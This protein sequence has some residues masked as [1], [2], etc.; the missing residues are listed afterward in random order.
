MMFSTIQEW[1]HSEMRIQRV[2]AHFIGL[3]Q[4]ATCAQLSH[5]HATVVLLNDDTPIYGCNSHQI[6]FSEFIHLLPLFPM[7]QKGENQ[8]FISIIIGKF[9]RPLSLMI[10]YMTK[11]I[12]GTWYDL[13][14][15]ERCHNTY[16]STWF[17]SMN[18][19]HWL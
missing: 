6:N 5:R 14:R 18:V 13:N 3:G 16:C 12:D 8:D 15:D 2:V 7:E 17:P 9:W 4:E 1:V 19:I 10:T 11:I